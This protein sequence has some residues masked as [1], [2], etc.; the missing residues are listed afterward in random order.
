MRD[1]NASREY[2]INKYNDK[3]EWMGRTYLIIHKRP[4]GENI[5]L[6]ED[7]LTDEKFRRQGVA[8]EIMNEAIKMAKNRGCYK[9][10][11]ACADHNVSFYEKLG[12]KVYQNAMRL[13][14]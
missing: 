11:L 13:S 9:I 12:F 10:C 4:N 1:G 7:V 6:I 5:G 8:T 2:E 14:L 3:N